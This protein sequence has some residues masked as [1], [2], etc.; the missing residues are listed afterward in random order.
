MDDIYDIY[1]DRERGEIPIFDF[2]TEL[3]DAD[4]KNERNIVQNLAKENFYKYPLIIKD[5]RKV[6]PGFGGRPEKPA[7]KNFSLKVKRGEM[8]G[9][10]GPNGAGKTSLISMLMGMFKPS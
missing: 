5:L 7:V 3:E 4:A 1:E 10:L 6:Y 9:L 8:F 2:D